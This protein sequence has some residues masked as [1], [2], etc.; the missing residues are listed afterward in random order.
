MWYVF[1]KDKTCIATCNAKPNLEDLSTR[2]EYALKCEEDS[3]GLSAEDVNGEVKKKTLVKTTEQLVAEL[4]T[5]YEKQFI[6]INNA[7]AIATNTQ[8]SALITLLTQEKTVLEQE[9]DQKRS[10]LV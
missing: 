7:L 1:N 8:D 4:D 2:E 5:S 9:Y 3:L 10:A 6:E